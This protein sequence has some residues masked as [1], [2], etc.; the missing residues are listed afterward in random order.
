MLASP[1]FCQ[2]NHESGM[3]Q[4]RKGAMIA[5]LATRTSLRALMGSARSVLASSVAEAARWTAPPAAERAAVMAG[6][7]VGA[8]AAAT[9]LAAPETRALCWTTL[10]VTTLVSWKP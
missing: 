4:Q 2:Q 3:N 8:L 6:A 9:T 7:A 5:L 10:V 1:S